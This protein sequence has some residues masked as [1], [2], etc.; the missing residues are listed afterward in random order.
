MPT[1]CWTAWLIC[2]TPVT[3]TPFLLTT[4]DDNDVLGHYLAPSEYTQCPTLS[5][6]VNPVAQTHRSSPSPD[7]SSLTSQEA[8]VASGSMNQPSLV[9]ISDL[10]TVRTDFNPKS[11]K[12]K[13]LSWGTREQ[14]ERFEVTEQQRHLAERAYTPLNFDDFCEKVCLYNST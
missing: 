6:T 10:Q 12:N 3:Q 4:L 13:T 14:K 7:M 5:L 8:A 1:R 11:E 2:S 9:D